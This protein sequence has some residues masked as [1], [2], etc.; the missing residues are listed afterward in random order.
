MIVTRVWQW[1]IHTLFNETPHRIQCRIIKATSC[2]YTLSWP[3]TSPSTLLSFCCIKCTHTCRNNTLLMS[4]CLKQLFNTGYQSLNI[5]HTDQWFNV[6]YWFSWLTAPQHASFVIVVGHRCPSAPWWNPWES[7][8]SPINN[9]AMA[10]NEILLVTFK[11]SKQ[12]NSSM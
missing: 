7:L 8:N 12:I 11:L 9:S 3:D 6:W 1:Y 10:I 5:E 4:S 2:G